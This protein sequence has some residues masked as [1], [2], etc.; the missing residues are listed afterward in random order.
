M[1]PTRHDVLADGVVLGVVALVDRYACAN[2]GAAA[3]STMASMAA[4]SITF[5]ILTSPS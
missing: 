5:L 4:N 1:S 3:A 2:A